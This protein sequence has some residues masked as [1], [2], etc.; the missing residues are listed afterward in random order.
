MTKKLK[1]GLITGGSILGAG[2]IATAIALPIVL[3]QQQQQNTNKLLS[4]IQY[5]LDKNSR[6]GAIYEL[7]PNFNNN[8]TSKLYERFANMSKEDLQYDFNRILTDFYEVYELA[9][10]QF[11]AEIDRVVVNSLSAVNPTDN[12][13]TAQLSV[14]YDVETNTGGHDREERVTLDRSFV[15]K[16]SYI[17]NDEIT[18]LTELLRYDQSNNINI[19]LSDLREVFFGEHDA[20]DFDDLGI[21]DQIS[22]LN[23][24]HGIT[25]GVGTGLMSYEVRLSDLAY[26][27]KRVVDLNTKFKIPSLSINT[28]AVPNQKVN[29][30]LNY[31]TISKIT[32]A[33]FAA[34]FGNNNLTTKYSNIKPYV[35]NLIVETQVVDITIDD[36]TAGQYVKLIIETNEGSNGNNTYRFTIDYTSFAK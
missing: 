30:S 12:T 22:K 8:A 33:N 27:P 23:S 24:E 15:V 6:A 2:A 17:T 21:F 11:K 28:Y 9:N 32:K 25:N 26:T 16:P 10:H 1:I 14:T 18:Q 36:N 20:D 31:P 34:L 5:S 19:D 13:R 3:T 29:M 4:T 35:N 7:D